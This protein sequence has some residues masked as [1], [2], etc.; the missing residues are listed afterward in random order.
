V[1]EGTLCAIRA[2]A[3]GRSDRIRALL[4]DLVAATGQGARAVEARIL[5][6][7]EDAGCTVEA[8]D[9]A[10]YL[11]DRD[12]YLVA[13][14]P[15]VEPSDWLE[16][17]DALNIVHGADHADHDGTYI[18]E[19]ICIAL[20]TELYESDDLLRK[21]AHVLPLVIHEPLPDCPVAQRLRSWE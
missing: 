15:E 1:D 17:C 16:W 10:A 2:A 6:A 12:I 11:R 4:C 8:F 5:A 3:E 9:Y 19:D 18:D 21:A 13:S 7:M 14:F 20:K